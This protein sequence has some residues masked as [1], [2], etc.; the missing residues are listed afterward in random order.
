MAYNTAGLTSYVLQNANE[1]LT[2]SVLKGV[3]I[4][5]VTKMVGVKSA[6]SLNLMDTDATFQADT[7]CSFDPDGTTTISQRILEVGKMKIEEAL[8][9]KDLE[10][11]YTQRALIAGGTYDMM[12]YAK[13]YTALKVAKIQASLE[14]A[15]WQ[16]NAFFDGFIDI[17]DGAGSAVAGN[18][19]AETSITQVNIF[20]I[21]NA[22]FAVVPANVLDKSD[23]SLYMGWDTFRTAI[24]AITTTNFFHYQTDGSM[25]K[26]QLKYPGTN[27]TMVAV[28]GLTGQDRMFITQ[29]SNLFWGTDLLHEE[30]QFIMIANPFEGNR[31]QFTA[32]M[33]GG[34]QVAFPA[35]IVEYTNA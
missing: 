25:E 6:Q 9:E 18:T 34:T 7:S 5:R 19:G 15:I 22:M 12:A 28:H 4:D 20:D 2:N 32:R 8:C 10:Q 13:E 30:E 29:D 23:L 33:K 11:F 3:T 31:I 16:S 26:G 35:N 14:L 21:I 1:L 27:L 24:S 17:I